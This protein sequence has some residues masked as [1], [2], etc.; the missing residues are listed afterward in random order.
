MNREEH[1]NN[2]FPTEDGKTYIQSLDEFN[3]KSFLKKIMEKINT[4]EYKEERIKENKEYLENVSMDWQLGYYVGENIV[5]NYLPTLST[6]MIHSNKVIQVSEEDY[7]ENKKLNED[8]FN[9]CKHVRGDSG[10]KEKWNLYFNHNKMLVKKY[11]PP[12]L[13]CSFRLIRINDMDKFKEGLYSSLWNCD[14]C[15]YDIKEKNI[16]IKN[17]MEFGFTYINFKLDENISSI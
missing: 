11:L 4:P 5:H 16:E 2:T 3:S 9:S 10:D 13:E 8:W 12:V 15:S 1:L 7:F 14:M 17:D 6:D